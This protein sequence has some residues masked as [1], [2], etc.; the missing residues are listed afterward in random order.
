VRLGWVFYFTPVSKA[1]YTKSSLS[2]AQQ[3]Q[4]LKDRGL[5]IENEA[6]AL[7][8]LE[9]ISYYRL[10]GYWFPLLID[11]KNHAFK[12]NSSFDIAFQNVLF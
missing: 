11:K 7:H 9:I 1:P 8:L 12:P 3:L 2:Y 6:K 10:S 5:I 4:Q